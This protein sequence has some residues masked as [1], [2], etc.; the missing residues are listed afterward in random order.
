MLEPIGFGIA[1]AVW[2][3]V[4]GSDRRPKGSN[5]IAF[6]IVLA[7]GLSA[8]GL[9]VDWSL[10]NA[11]RQWPL[12]VPV[13]VSGWLMVRGMP[14]WSEWKPMLLGFALPTV[15]A[16]LLYGAL[17]QEFS[18]LAPY[19]LSGLA[20]ALTYVGL[21]NLELR[22]PSWFRSFTA[23]KWGR[24]SYGFIVGGLAAL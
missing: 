3:Y 16:G 8:S 10:E 15:L 13:L 24:L 17:T 4:D 2:R 7:A 12:L 19:S 21:S 9:L 23:E 5:L 11:A 18:T 22:H 20:V 6:A 1:A 14:G